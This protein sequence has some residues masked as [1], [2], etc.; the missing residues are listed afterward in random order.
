M[1][2]RIVF[3]LPSFQ[4]GGAE[5]V[6]LTLMN[7][8]DRTRFHATL[9]VLNAQGPLRSEVSPDIETQD[10]GAPRT[11]HAVVG[12]V[13]AIRALRPAAVYSTLGHVNLLLLAVRPFLPRGCRLIIREA[14][15]P[16]ISLANSPHPRLSAFGYRRLYPMA[17]LVICS[18][19]RRRDELRDGFGVPEHRLAVMPNPVMTARL[20]QAAAHPTREPGSGARF[21]AAGRLTTQ[22]GFDRL[23]DMLSELPRDSHLTILGEGPEDANLRRQA[24]ELGV[25]VHFAGYHSNP[26][27]FYAGADAFV[28]PSRWEG[29]PNAALEALACGTPVIATLESGGLAE[30]GAAVTFAEAGPAF[31]DALAAVRPAPVTAPRSSLLPQSNDVSQV[32]PRF[33]EL[34]SGR[35]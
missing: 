15:M 9:V 22:K 10:L 25:N 2:Q 18:S 35:S 23:L 27:P 13:R 16:A 4:G 29:M 30:I 11:R 7:G 8:L 31:V 21:V 19:K 3:V 14:N 32:L 33:A 1:T 28:M 20:R 17:D 34:L 6:L 26:H 24:A 5:R 12:L